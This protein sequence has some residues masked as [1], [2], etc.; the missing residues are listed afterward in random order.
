MIVVALLHGW[1]LVQPIQVFFPGF[2]YRVEIDMIQ[3]AL[4]FIY[5]LLPTECNG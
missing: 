5:A 1:V 4:G 2:E 3:P